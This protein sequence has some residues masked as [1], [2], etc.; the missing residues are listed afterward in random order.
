MF[1]LEPNFQKATG[2]TLVIILP[3]NQDQ[4]SF[5]LYR[6]HFLIVIRLVPVEPAYG[7][8]YQSGE[9][10]IASV[11]GNQNLHTTTGENID[12]HELRAGA[13]VSAEGPIRR[14]TMSKKTSSNYWNDDYHVYELEWSP[15]EITV[16]VD[17]TEFGR[18]ENPAAS[19]KQEI[20]KDS[21]D[22][23]TAPNAPFDKP[24]S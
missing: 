15:S 24:V 16:R 7:A 23:W 5:R 2:F 11:V 22:R 19:H 3:Y 14:D 9:L 13:V 17:G 4:D 6:G 18:K 12:G 20:F 8:G 10:R 1:K 21:V